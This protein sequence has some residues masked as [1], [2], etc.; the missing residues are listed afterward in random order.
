MTSSP[1]LRQDLASSATG[2]ALAPREAAAGGTHF[3]VNQYAGVA[4]APEEAATGSSPCG[5]G[6]GKT[7]STA[8]G[9]WTKGAVACAQGSGQL[10]REKGTST[11]TCFFPEMAGYASA[12]A[13]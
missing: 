13:R 12:T 6:G 1:S 5:V 11:S 7:T 4:L 2:L 9:G 8:A 3:E 10:S